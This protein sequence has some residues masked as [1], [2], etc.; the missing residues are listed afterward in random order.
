MWQ[1]ISHEFGFHFAKLFPCVSD[2]PRELSIQ[3]WCIIKVVQKNICLVVTS[4]PPLRYL[5]RLRYLCVEEAREVHMREDQCQGVPSPTTHLLRYLCWLGRRSTRREA[6]G[7]S[8]IP[9]VCKAF[10]SWHTTAASHYTLHRH[11]LSWRHLLQRKSIK[12]T[13]WQKTV[14]MS[15]VNIRWLPRHR[16]TWQSPLRWTGNTTATRLWVWRTMASFSGMLP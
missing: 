9:T 3:T 4:P 12:K 5:S 11:C 15:D 10:P 8:S 6:L 2:I 7:N 13:G 14:T 1:R 16:L